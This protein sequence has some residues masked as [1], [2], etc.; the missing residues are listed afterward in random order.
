MVVERNFLA[1]LVLQ[2]T[3]FPTTLSDWGKYE[4]CAVQELE[5]GATGAGR[6]VG[7]N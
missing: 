7:P 2:L 3:S 5:V 1:S 4:A 6:D